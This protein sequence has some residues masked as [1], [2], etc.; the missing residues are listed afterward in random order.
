MELGPVKLKPVFVLLSNYARRTL[1][2][3]VRENLEPLSFEA[4]D[5][6][7]G[8]VLY[9]TNLPKTSRDPAALYVE[10]LRDRAMVYVDRVS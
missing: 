7:S 4:L 2:E 3:G 10:N 9:E 1:N 5:Q 8:L 6:N